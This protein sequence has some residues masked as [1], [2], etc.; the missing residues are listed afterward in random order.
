MGPHKQLENFLPGI[1]N[2]LM[3]RCDGGA[4]PARE[5]ILKINAVYFR[6][7][8]THLYVGISIYTGNINNIALATYRMHLAEPSQLGDRITTYFHKYIYW[9]IIAQC[10]KNYCKSYKINFNL[11]VKDLMEVMFFSNL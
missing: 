11:H 3:Q 4:K 6:I 1:E 5:K 9:N 8:Y 10:T 7:N 2:F